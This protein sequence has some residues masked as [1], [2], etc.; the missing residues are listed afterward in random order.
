M[1]KIKCE[2]C[3]TCLKSEYGQGSH[4]DADLVN[5]KTRGFLSHPNHHL[6]TIIKM[7]ETSFEKHT[8]SLNV[9]EDTYEDLLSNDNV[10]LKWECSVHKSEILTEIYTMYK[11]ARREGQGGQLPPLAFLLVKIIISKLNIP[12]S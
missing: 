12:K 9:F 6:Y 10:I 11:G 7:F 4:P 2:L 1:K 5:M 8:D 3:L